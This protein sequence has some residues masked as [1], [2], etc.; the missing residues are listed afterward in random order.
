MRFVPGSHKTGLRPHAPVFGSDRSKSH[1][2]GT[3]LAPEDVVD[4][5]PI[6][7]GSVTVHS[8]RVIHG[9][10][11]NAT[12]GLRRAWVLAFRTEE[13]IRIER[14]KGFTHSHND[15]PDVLAGVGES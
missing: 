6:K 9:S 12:D 4:T 15:V 1:A 14:E 13:T 8:E 7:S 10:G 5:V 11:P 3:E 2:L